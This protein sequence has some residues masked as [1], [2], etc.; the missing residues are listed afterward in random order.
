MSLDVRRARIALRDRPLSDVLDLALCFVTRHGRIYAITTGVV[1][2]P[3]VLIT[4]AASLWFGWFAGGAVALFLTPAASVPFTLLASRAVF[5]ENA[6]PK[7]VLAG[8]FSR[9]IQVG[10]SRGAA[11]LAVFAGAAAFVVPAFWIAAATCFL[12]EVILL[13]QARGARAFGRAMRIAG[14][15]PG[16][17]VLT[18]IVLLLVHGIAI[19][20]A[21]V[22]GRVV[23]EEVLQFRAPEPIYSG[24]GSVLAILGWFFAI[25]YLA[26]ARFFAYLNVR[27]RAE[28]W[29]VQTQF[30]A[31][32]A[33]IDA[34][35]A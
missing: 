8:V 24:G 5:D 14:S 34:E 18:A 17:T 12:S 26:T 7:D 15:A 22:A 28:G 16:E 23:I 2:V 27:T 11:L 30:A 4:I 3:C 29:D 6:R 33:R 35:G 32:A 31:I 25:P 13:E 9:V 19:G 21:D 10:L 1:L 20:L